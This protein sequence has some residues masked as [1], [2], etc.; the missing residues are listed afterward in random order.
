MFRIS[1]REEIMDT[2]FV[3]DHDGRPVDISLPEWLR[4]R[5]ALLEFKEMN[6]M[7]RGKYGQAME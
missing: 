7:V 6:E 2:V 4:Y 5:K 3:E 1:L